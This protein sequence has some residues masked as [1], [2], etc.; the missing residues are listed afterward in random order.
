MSVS[1]VGEAEIV[2]AA[3]ISAEFLPT[4]GDRVADEPVETDRRQDEGG[5]GKRANHAAGQLLRARAGR[6][7]VVR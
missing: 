4:L 6:D 7:Y 1:G 5:H 3:R 2:V